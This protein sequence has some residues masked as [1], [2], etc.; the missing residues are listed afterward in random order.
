[1]DI[2]VDTRKVTYRKDEE[3]S[4]TDILLIKA[5]G[6]FKLF[7]CDKQFFNNLDGTYECA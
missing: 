1:M 4:V 6:Y 7:D 3:R 5:L 2:S